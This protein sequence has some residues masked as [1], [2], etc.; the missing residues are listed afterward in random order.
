MGITPDPKRFARPPAVETPVYD[1]LIIGGGINGTAIARDAAGRGLSVLLC[2]RDDLGGHT[3]SS[4]T[5]LIHGGLRYL[6]HYDFKLVRHALMER[7]ILLRSA[8][9]IIW[10]LRFVLPYEPQRRPKWLLRMGLFLYDHMGGRKL[11]PATKSIRLDKGKLDGQLKS[12]LT[13]GFEYSDCW[14]EDSRLVVLNAVDAAERGADIRTRTEVVSIRDEPDGYTARLRDRAGQEV[15]VKARGLVNA[16]G[17]WVDNIEGM[18]NPGRNATSVRLV[19]GSHIVVPKHYEGEH[20]YIFQNEDGRIIFAIPY[21]RDYTLIGTTDVPYSRGEGAV[22]ATDAEIDYLC[23]AASEYF[24]RPVTAESV[25][26][27][28]SGVRPL[29]EDHS[30]DASEVTR[31]YVLDLKKSDSGAPLLSIYGGKITTSRRLAEHALSRLDAFYPEMGAPW[32]AEAALPGGDVDEADFDQIL[33]DCS[34]QHSDVDPVLIHCLCRRYGTRARALLKDG[35]GRMFGKELCSAE[36]DY[37][38][39]N[40]WVFSTED[41]L[42]RRTKAGLHLSKSDQK[43]LDSYVSARV[44][45]LSTWRKTEMTAVS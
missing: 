16:A 13:S 29:Y 1:L 28:Y 43:A 18:V 19:K 4:S 20:N 44:E 5:K 8:P 34:A 2:E 21:E 33:S 32:T 24:E 12:H 40:E 22:V 6:E 30:S 39:E 23:K 25:V 3:S 31:D 26:W 10:P 15:H 38:I 27:T 9:H 35:V 14:V 45:N 37:M 11:L 7:E 17:P 36:I 42:W 41:V